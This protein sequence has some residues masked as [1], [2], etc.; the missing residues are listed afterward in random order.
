MY[1]TF[2]VKTKQL[3]LHVTKI[4]PSRNKPLSMV[5]SFKLFIQFV[6]VV[7]PNEIKTSYT[8]Q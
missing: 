2:Y 4:N 3:I 7:L 6:C 5:P 1:F 8:E